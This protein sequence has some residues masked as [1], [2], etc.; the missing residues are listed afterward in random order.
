MDMSGSISGMDGLKGI[1]MRKIVDMVEHG[2]I[3]KLV[4]IESAGGD[5]VEIVVE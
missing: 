3:G 4:E 5:T 1:D 2:L